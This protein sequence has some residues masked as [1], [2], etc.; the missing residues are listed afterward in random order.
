MVNEGTYRKVLEII[1]E[2]NF[3]KFVEIRDA[4]VAGD[5]E[6]SKLRSEDIKSDLQGLF[7]C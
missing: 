7:F 2:D 1:N 4:T 3:D 6:A 5:A